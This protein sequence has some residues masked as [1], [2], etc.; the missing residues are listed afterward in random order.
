MRYVIRVEQRPS[1][2][3]RL[4]QYFIK[5]GR[6]RKQDSLSVKLTHPECS[7]PRRPVI[8][9]YVFKSH[10]TRPGRFIDFR[11][12]TVSQNDSW[13]LI[14]SLP[15]WR[16]CDKDIG[17]LTLT[18]T[19][20]ENP[21]CVGH[22]LPTTKGLKLA[23]N[24]QIHFRQLI[25]GQADLFTFSQPHGG[26]IKRQDCHEYCNQYGN[27]HNV[28]QKATLTVSCT[29]QYHHFVIA[30]HASEGKNNGQKER[31]RHDHEQK[32]RN[33]VQHEQNQNIRRFFPG[34]RLGQILN[35]APGQHHEKQ[36]RSYHR[37]DLQ[38]LS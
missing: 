29:H 3:R 7:R 4:L 28:H 6:G 17:Q 36:D 22:P 31:Q 24:D 37:C 18:S 15:C 32:F 21:F 19:G 5:F 13:R 10:E 25:L 12:C 20:I 35:K 38:N 16:Q 9:Q 14:G 30:I 1:T 11:S 23:S 26:K 33:P 8:L 27:P 34:N 2:Q